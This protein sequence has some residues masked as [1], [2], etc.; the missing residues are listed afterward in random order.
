M[1]YL[2]LLANDLSAFKMFA[3]DTAQTLNPGFETARKGIRRKGKPCSALPTSAPPAPE[4]AI[5]DLIVVQMAAW[6]AGPPFPFLGREIT[7]LSEEL[8]LSFASWKERL[9]SMRMMELLAHASRL[10]YG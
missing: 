2:A 1:S 5:L 10:T 6:L 3:L 8:M 7:E 9:I 4:P